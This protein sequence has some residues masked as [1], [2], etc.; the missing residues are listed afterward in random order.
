MDFTPNEK[1]NPKSKQKSFRRFQINPEPF[2]GPSTRSSTRVL[3]QGQQE[4]KL[5][6]QGRNIAKRLSTKAEEKETELEQQI[7]SVKDAIETN[8]KKAKYD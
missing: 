6:N 8:T 7:K 1:A 5:R 4:K 2:W 3:G